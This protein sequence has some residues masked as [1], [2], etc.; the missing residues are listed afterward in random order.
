MFQAFT[1]AS[2]LLGPRLV[3]TE[4][5][6]SRESQEVNGTT[7]TPIPGHQHVDLGRGSGTR[8]TEMC[9]QWL[10]LQLGQVGM[11]FVLSD[12]PTFLKSYSLSS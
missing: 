6:S 2:K 9:M 4:S 3:K 8:R 5:G 1:T 11:S 12:L 10:G 7:F